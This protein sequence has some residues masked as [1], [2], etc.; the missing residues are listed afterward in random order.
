[1]KKTLAIFLRSAVFQQPWTIDETAV[2]LSGTDGTAMFLIRALRASGIYNILLLGGCA[3]HEE[4]VHVGGVQRLAEALVVAQSRQAS[5]LLFSS[6]SQAEIEE[7]NDLAP[8]PTSLHFWA[9]NSVGYDWLCAAVALPHD[10]RFVTVSDWQLYGMVGHPIF[11]RAVSMPNPVPDSSSWPPGDLDVIRAEPQIAYIGAI[12][13]S[14]GFHHLAAAWPSFRQRHPE[15]RLV[16][17][18]SASLYDP[19]ASQGQAGLS[20]PDYEQEILR[21]LGGSLESARRLGIEFRGSLAT[22][23][24]HQE[25]LRSQFVVVNPNLTGS[26]ETFCCAAVEALAL[27]IPV[28]G[29]RA[30]ALVE[31][32]GHGLGGLLFRHYRELP[33]MMSRLVADPS[34]RKSLGQQGY[35]HV[36]QSYSRQRICQRWIDYFDGKQVSRFCNGI[37]R[38]ATWRNHLRICERLL[39]LPVGR[40]LRSLKNRC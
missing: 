4:S 28:V 35:T 2:P 22:G 25:L 34:L 21:L 33:E 32:V 9:H 26:T 40:A 17:C 31:T 7:L 27:G 1:M 16:V 13:P 11:K 3:P 38:W 19:N 14:K 39:P 8:G 37:R 24:L 18:G 29:A 20:D 5:A 23:Q 15:M 6:A 36:M 12:K 10:F 30:G